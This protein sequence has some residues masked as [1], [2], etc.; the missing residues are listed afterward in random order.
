[1]KR[2]IVKID[3][4]LCNGCGLCVPS[5][6]EGA[7]SIV[8]GKA[9]LSD[10]ALCDGIGNCLGECPEGAI[11]IEERES[12]P[13][14]ATKVSA[15]AT[16]QSHTP[17]PDGCP[18]SR[19]MDMR[20]DADPT[21]ATTGSATSTPQLGQWPI[22]L[23]LLPEKASF[24]AGRELVVI[25]DCVPFAYPDIHTK[26]LAGRSVA[27]FCPKLDGAAEEYTDKLAAILA[28]NDIPS[29]RVVIMEVPCCR[30]MEH[31]VRQAIKHSNKTI[32]LYLEV[33]EIKGGIK[34]QK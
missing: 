7:I 14:D 5:C 10:E 4:Q 9:V 16:H 15:Q 11:T 1:M 20:G 29:V 18:S 6:A 34:K 23:Q 12:A 27:I 3:P 32:P 28:L 19:V 2:K 33:V 21:T 26:W 22:Q 25:A 24:Y 8:D 13:F 17:P 31:V 30:G